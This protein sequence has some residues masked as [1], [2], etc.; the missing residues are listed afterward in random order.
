MAG[1][2]QLSLRKG[3]T[4]MHT[5]YVGPVIGEVSVETDKLTLVLHDG[6]SNADR[7]IELLRKD[8]DNVD[9]VEART[10][11][12]LG[13]SATLDTG[14]APT[15]IPSNSDLGS[16]AYLSVGT[17]ALNVVQLD[18]SA[19]LPA[20][21]AQNLF[22]FPV[23]SDAQS[24]YNNVVNALFTSE[25]NNMTATQMINQFVDAFNTEDGIDLG[26]SSNQSYSSN[27]YE[28]TGTSD[29]DLVSVAFAAQSQPERCFIVLQDESEASVV[30]NTDLNVY[31]SRD[32]GATF[33]QA[34]MVDFGTVGEVGSSVTAYASEVD[35][36]AQPAGTSIVLKIE[37]RNA[38]NFVFQGWGAYW[39]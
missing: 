38:K 36:S 16:A 29:I 28:N 25:K 6:T 3:T 9:P 14:T 35:L 18:G 8:M 12:L 37:G 30:I 31:V 11:L 26:A 34:T 15:E 33:T 17:G 22:D 27:R 32:N 24:H 5:A 7:Q 2:T 39:V 1:A 20:V 10:A 4:A 23:I 21:S 19:A 13:T